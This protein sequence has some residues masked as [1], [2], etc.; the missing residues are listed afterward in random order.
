[1]SAE[2]SKT[3]TSGNHSPPTTSPNASSRPKIVGKYWWE[4]GDES[5]GPILN[6]PTWESPSSCKRLSSNRSSGAGESFS[7]LETDLLDQERALVAK[8]V[9]L[10]L[11][12]PHKINQIL[13]VFVKAV[14]LEMEGALI[15][16]LGIII[17]Q[18]SQVSLLQRYLCV[19]ME[20]DDILCVTQAINN[21]R[22]F[23]L[24]DVKSYAAS[25]CFSN[26][27][28]K[29]LKECEEDVLAR[30]DYQELAKRIMC[31]DQAR[32]A[33]HVACGNNYQAAVALFEMLDVERA[34]CSC[35]ASLSAY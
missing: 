14:S 9:L 10:S 7:C 32:R 26:A 4:E 6:S 25:H 2:G 21:A 13:P 18:Q 30:T 12:P 16:E 3:H 11:S 24:D 8:E 31:H 15:E 34:G 5:V 33:E 20:C 28:I 1:M 27:W 22:S 19:S 17:L 29:E 35:T 23:L